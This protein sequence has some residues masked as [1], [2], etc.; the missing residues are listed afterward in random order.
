MP[1]DAI[2]RHFLRLVG[3]IVEHLNFEAVA[4]IIEL[5][6][7][8]HQPLDH[9]ALIEDGKLYGNL[10]PLGD[11]GRRAGRVIAIFIEIID[12]RV[13]MNS[14][15]RQNH[16]HDEIRQHHR[17]IESVGLILPDEG[18]IRQPV[19]IIGKSRARADGRQQMNL[20][21]QIFVAS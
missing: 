10:W 20:P 8:V 15:R 19:P 9:V 5:R 12:Q 3:R 14:V 2:A 6:D 16:Q 18:A 13:A 7:A 17:Q 21:I 4:R 1:L 11:G